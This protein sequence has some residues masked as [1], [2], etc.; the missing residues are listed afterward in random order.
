M[1]N[2]G[3]SGRHSMDLVVPRLRA[4]IPTLKAVVGCTTNGVIGDGPT[5]DVVEVENSPALSLTLMRLPGITVTPFHVMPDD[6]PS[7]DARQ[8]VWH[9]LVGR[10]PVSS[11]S[12]PSFML[13]SD[14]SFADRG[15]LDRFLSG[16]EYA[17]PGSSVV[18]AL[19]SAAA[20]FPKGH[21]FCTLP[22]DILSPEANS[23]RD[24]GLVGLT[25]SGDVQI[26]CLVSQGC[27]AIGP[28]FEVR[29]VGPG[30]VILEMELAGR[31][32][33]CLRATGQ[34]QS[35][36]SYAS[37]AEKELLQE[38]LHIGIS[39]NEYGSVEDNMRIRHVIN[40]DMFKGG[41]AVACDVHVGQ[42]VTFCIMER[43]AALRALDKT[44]QKYKRVEL[45]NSLVGYSNP[46]F[47]AVVFADVGRGQGLFSE[48]ATETR[49]LTSFAPGVPV[50]GCFSAG[51]IGPCRGGSEN[52]GRPGIL[53]MAANVVALLRRRSGMTPADPIER[54]EAPSPSLDGP[55]T[56]D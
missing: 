37:K 20:A 56:D 4:L 27:R 6:L 35:I 12:N 33:S 1:T 8:D 29:K 41:I 10:P 22:R 13:F 40:V 19:A 7:L 34:L 30:N 54:V 46:P 42:R 15:E 23:L 26:D 14:P 52:V 48:P 45:A 51:Q 43:E 2:V 39:V 38:N 25:F 32:S 18:G 49:N 21:M 31:P 3:Q 5:T 53:H 9:N 36:I 24:S 11:S 16:I 50:T 47:G 28:E 44:M 17:Y 55:Q